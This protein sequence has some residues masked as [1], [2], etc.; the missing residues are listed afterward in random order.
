MR[1]WLF[2]TFFSLTSSACLAQ[3]TNGWVAYNQRYYKISVAATGIYRL[4]YDQLQEA[5]VP[6]NSIDPRLIQI[7]HRGEEQAIYFKHDQLPADNKFDTGEYL[8]FYGE[9]NDGEMDSKLYQ[10]A[11]SQPHK[12]YN[13]Y[14]DTSAYFLTVNPLPVLGKRMEP[15]DEVN[16]SSIPKETSHSQERLQILTAEYSPGDIR[17]V[18]VT[19]SF[20]DEGEG[21][22][23]AT[24]CTGNSQC[25]GFEQRDFSIDQLSNIITSQPA[26]QLEIQLTGRDFLRH[27]AEIY[28]G[29]STSSLRLLTS[30]Q[31]DYFK[32]PVYAE[33]L[34]WSD[35]GVDGKMIVRVKAIGVDGARDRL[36]VGYV[37]VTFAQGFNLASATSR[38]FTLNANAGAGG[39]AYIEMDNAPA[40]TRLWDVTDPSQLVMIGTHTS[41]SLLT[42]VIP[43][44]SD[45]RKLYASS[46]FMM[47][48]VSQVKPVMFRE[49]N[50][51]AQYIVVSHRSLM[52]SA[53]GYSDPVRAFAGYRASEEGGGYDTLV[54]SIDQLYD[55]FNYGETSSV[56]IT[57]FMRYMIGSGD[58]Q[59]LFLVGKGR[60]VSAAMYRRTL[61]PLES[62]DLVPPG[63]SPGSDA[64]FTAG[65]DGN[66]NVQAVATGRLTASTPNQVA[67]YLNKVKEAEAAP[68]NDLSRKKLLHLSGG[69]EVAQLTLFRSYMEGFAETA[70]GNYLGGSVATIGKRGISDIEFINVS[71]QINAG[72]DLVTFFGHSAPNVTDISIGFPDDPVLGYNNKGKYPAFLV[73]GCNAGEYFNNGESFGESWI[74][75]ADKG[76]RNFIA[77]SSFGFELVLREYTNYF[78]KVAFADSIFLAKGIG[79]V[80][81]E[82]ARRFLN[83]FG[84][85]KSVFTAQVNQMVLL[86]DPSLKLFAPASPDYE[87]EDALIDVVSFDGKPIHAMT[88]SLQL[89]V[90]ANNLGRSTIRKLTVKVVHTIDDME[91]EYNVEYNSVKYQDTL[92]LTIARG[93]GSF[94]GNNKIEVFLDPENK[95][96]ELNEDNN[97]AQWT[98]F[99]QFNGTQNLQ[100][101]NFGIVNTTSPAVLFQNTNNATPITGA[102]E[103][104][105]E[106]TYLIELDTTKSF[107]SPFLFSGQ[108]NGEVL[109]RSHFDLLD[110][111][112][113]VYYWRTKPASSTD[114]QWET[115]SF[116]YIKNGPK[117][118]TQ[119]AF[120][121]LTENTWEGL[122]PDE[123]NRK[124]G[125]ESKN[126]S[127]S[128]KTFGD[129]NAEPGI[130]PSFIVNSAEYY[131]S[132]GGTACRN[133]TINLVA[134]DRSTVNPYAAVPFDF[135][136]SFG[137]ECGREPAIINS[138]AASET[139]T[140]NGDDLIQYVDNLKLSDSVVLFTVGDADFAAWTSTVKTKLGEIGILSSDIDTFQP[141]E[142]IVIF[143]RKGAVPGTA[144]IVRSDQAVPQEQKLEVSEDLTGYITSGSIKSVSI[145][146]AL[147][148]HDLSPQFKL[149]NPDDLAEVDV[150]TIDK[151]GGETV[152]AMHQ[153]AALDISS[154][155]ASQYPFLKLVYRTKDEEHL[156]P[157]VLKHWLVTY[158]PAPDGVLL[159]GSPAFG[160]STVPE[161]TMH[162]SDFMF[163]NVSNVD[164]TDSLASVFSILNRT[165]RTRETHEFRI[166]G[167]AAGETVNF[168][169]TVNTLGKVG[170]NDLSVT[171]NTDFVTEQYLQNNAMEIASYLEVLK[172]QSNPQ[173]EVI[174][175]GRYLSDGDFVSANPEIR[176]RLRDDNHLIALKDTTSLQVFMSDPCEDDDCSLKRIAFSRPDV[177]WSIGKSGELL[178]IFTPKDLKEG[179]YLLSANGTDASGNPAGDKQYEVSFIVD[180]EPGLI[181]N[182]PYPNPSATGFYFE[183]A[184]AG[185]TAPESFVL[186]IINR[187]GQ[188]VAYFT[189]QDSH[190]L[191]V[192]INQLRWTGLDLQGDRLSDGLYFYLLKV[193]SG[194]NEYKNSGRIMII[195]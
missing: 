34:Q 62:R 41:G 23:G 150:Y 127:I 134:F 75:I 54:V 60:D 8:E 63:G 36:S 190:P 115:T 2:A 51:A 145:G 38:N 33:A 172:D 70:R 18:Y 79:D 17:D 195:R 90:I 111:D 184:A 159:A 49:M 52:K 157:A 125:F 167:P 147:A 7:F 113:T 56:A 149:T 181:F 9:R 187:S 182:S 47:P 65:M 25:I 121:Q 109:V 39:K 86:G 77:N 140:G 58:P 27:L 19:Q 15:F 78:Y 173:M 175:D 104:K 40:G 64:T 82:V 188:D 26:P 93:S 53:L 120:G 179:R 148:W 151:T 186:Q 6:V 45:T 156:T 103:V 142:P 126:V 10:P 154:I 50:T 3:Y 108:A 152:Y 116:T 55:Q 14:S 124:I 46:T 112:S 22:T 144:R 135:S 185:E 59:Y 21:W 137:R 69:K 174:V 123:V 99:I 100:P 176:V 183:F 42:A 76:A 189:D 131:Y 163:V 110:E 119:M 5:G 141:G 168:S 24:I 130:T 136:N 72:V 88:D 146:P 122:V 160:P 48:A 161:G 31:F 94:Y 139:D 170:Q 74:M 1:F 87:T 11:L 106:N 158:D 191:R 138:F 133:N 178:M 114:G 32:T 105:P 81:K 98:R 92:K 177:S 68:Y 37:K 73:N 20:F 153:Q 67:V 192:G 155:N 165:T 117:G 193:R 89:L 101:S 118:W 97:H 43:N 28:V 171:V 29:P 164:F 96:E 180:R 102:E 44:S 107:D 66:P 85:E 61:D 71:D 132:P 16:S 166:R 169:Q 84:N 194:G 13:L 57:E 80:Q 143:G 30:K 162:T 35:I 12:Y 83:D 95:I 91:T 129:A 128:M 4:T